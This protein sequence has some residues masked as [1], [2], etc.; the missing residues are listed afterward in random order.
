MKKQAMPTRFFGKRLM[1]IGWFF[2]IPATVMP[3]T[4]I[5]KSLLEMRQHQV[6]IQQFDLSCGAAALATL[7]KFQF[8]DNVTEREVAVGLMRR[9]TY[10]ANP[11]L[12]REHQGFSLLDLKRYVQNRGYDGVAFGEMEFDD[13]LRK[14]PI[15]VPLN[16]HGYQHFVIF[17]GS[18]NNQVMLA[19]PAWGNRTMHVDEFMRTWINDPQI[20]RVGFLIQAQDERRANNVAVPSAEDAVISNAIDE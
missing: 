9:D 16:L 14:A 13:L 15:M 1:M 17:R 5:V 20:G 8:G 19:D 11:D 12:I 18:A 6:V 7:L 3:Q 10:L 4:R 2:F